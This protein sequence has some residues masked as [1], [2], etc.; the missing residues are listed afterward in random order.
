M[1]KQTNS[2]LLRNFGLPLATAGVLLFASPAISE[3]SD[4]GSNLLHKGVDGES[5]QVVQELLH[6]KGLLDEA[7]ITGTFSKETFDAVSTYQEKHNLVVD[8]I[9]GPQTVGAMKVLEKGDEGVL[10][11]DLQHQLVDLGFYEGNKDGLYGPLTQAAV[12]GFQ[13]AQGISVDGIAGPETYSNLY[14]SNPAGN[15]KVPEPQTPVEEAPVETAPEVQEPAEAPAQ[16]EETT[17][18]PAAEETQAEEPE[19]VEEPAVE[20]A[21]E[22][23]ASAPAESEQATFEME[24]TAYTAYCEGCSGVTATG[25][26]LRENPNKKV[27]AV[28][29]DVIPLGSRVHVEGYGEAIAGDTGGAIQ[30]HKVDL[31]MATKEEAINFGRQTVTVTVLD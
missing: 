13:K 24:A 6:E 17:E 2:K 1:K 14:Y 21:E 9:A 26:D 8:G 18:E 10:V 12:K 19:A 3:A 16:A 28:D 29:P 4:L 15:Q 23:T 27:V 20:E 11:E 22:T 7:A 25:I 31:H 5:V 30:G